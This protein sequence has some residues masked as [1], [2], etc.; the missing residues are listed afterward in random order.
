MSTVG[1]QRA[2]AWVDAF[3]LRKQAY[4][5]NDVDVYEVRV[6]RYGHYWQV[7][8]KAKR[9]EEYLAAAAYFNSY[10]EALVGL[11]NICKHWRVQWDRDKYP[12]KNKRR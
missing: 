1:D 5:H 4:W 11:G 9:D 7:L 3:S 8:L 12:P 2:D 10:E 6:A